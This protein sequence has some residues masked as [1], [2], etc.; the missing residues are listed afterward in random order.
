[1][2]NSNYF[3][4]FPEATK[5]AMPTEKSSTSAKAKSLKSRVR[6]YFVGSHDEK[7][8]QLVQNVADFTYIVT[9]TE[10]EAFLLELSLIKEH[11]PKYNIL[12]MDDKTYPYI[13]VT[14]ETHPRLHDHAARLEEEQER[15]RSVS[16]RRRRERHSRSIASAVPAAQVPDAC[17]KNCACT[18]TSANAKGLACCP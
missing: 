15:L 17:R 14:D 13:E 1:M 9:K 18:T 10:T 4:N 5:C 16:L 8:T 7:T 2:P 3:P 12:L 11:T 6:S